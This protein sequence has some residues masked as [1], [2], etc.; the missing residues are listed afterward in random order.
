MP[1]A[2]LW[3]LL[4]A[5]TAILNVLPN[6]LSVLTLTCPAFLYV[7]PVAVCTHFQEWRRSI[8]L[9]LGA[10]MAAFAGGSPLLLSLLQGGMMSRTE[11][12]WWQTV[13][14]VAMSAANALVVAAI[15]LPIGLGTARGWTYGRVVATT[16]APYFLVVAA[17]LALCWDPFIRVLNAMLAASIEQLNLQSSQRGVEVTER[18]IDGVEW[19]GSNLFAFTVGVEFAMCLVVSCA[20]VSITTIALRRRFAD[21]G[22]IGS[23]RDL[24]PP[25]WLVWVAI[26]TAALWF[27]EGGFGSSELRFATWN[28]AFGIGAIYFLNGCALFL[29]GMQALAPGPVVIVSVLFLLL[30]TGPVYAMSLLGLFDTWANF[31]VRMDRLAQ[32]IRDAQSGES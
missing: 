31:R 2:G 22:P 13:G 14:L 9:I 8:Y 5:V 30:M 21:P 4:F 7:V 19:F 10:F 18:L 6:P 32:A 11:L 27:V 15:G 26:L 17:Y 1:Y 3:A 28:T 16:V 12:A 23:F 24:H 29:Y 20:L 25:D